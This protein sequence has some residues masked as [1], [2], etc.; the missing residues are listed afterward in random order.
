MSLVTYNV[1]ILF[2]VKNGFL[3]SIVL[4]SNI[5]SAFTKVIRDMCDTDYMMLF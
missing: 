2:H 3:R 5:Y 4:E 1:V